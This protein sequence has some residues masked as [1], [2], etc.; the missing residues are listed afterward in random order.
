MFQCTTKRNI[1][2]KLEYLRVYSNEG[3]MY[4]SNH[5]ANNIWAISY[6]RR[7]R[8][9]IEYNVRKRGNAKKYNCS[10]LMK[11]VSFTS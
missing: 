8:G 4:C 2:I 7:H 5:G 6:V 3:F 11:P 1:K 10:K 9:I